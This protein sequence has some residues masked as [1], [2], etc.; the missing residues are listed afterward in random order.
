MIR[1]E[2]VQ[3]LVNVP[4]MPRRDRHACINSS[5]SASRIA[6]AKMLPV[7]ACITES[8]L[9]AFLQARPANPMAESPTVLESLL[10]DR[11]TASAPSNSDQTLARAARSGDMESGHGH[12]VVPEQVCHH[13]GWGLQ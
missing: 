11:G 1:G 9:C 10:P 12:K 8:G 2:A 6:I 5:S 13:A 7:L 4:A 3:M